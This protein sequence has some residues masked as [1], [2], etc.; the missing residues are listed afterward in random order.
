MA[1]PEVGIFAQRNKDRPNR[2][3]ITSVRLLKRE[4][5]TLFVDH[6]D[7]INGT[8][9]LDIKPVIK[10]FSI[11]PAEIRQPQWVNEMLIDYWK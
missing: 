9:V 6:F 2:I 1:W 5:K 7:G 11:D 10:A 4:G 8:P 3:G